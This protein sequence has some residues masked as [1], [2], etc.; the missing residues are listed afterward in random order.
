MCALRICVLT[1]LYIY[2]LQSINKEIKNKYFFL[3][4]EIHNMNFKIEFISNSQR[5]VWVSKLD[6]R[7]GDRI[8]NFGSSKF[9][10]FYRIS[11]GGSLS[12]KTGV[13]NLEIQYIKKKLQIPSYMP[14]IWYHKAHVRSRFSTYT[15]SAVK[16]RQKAKVHDERDRNI[17]NYICMKDMQWCV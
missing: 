5:E 6:K 17:D 10:Q 8:N 1:S 4:Q 14:T 11:H 2:N 16:I 13:E 12:H 9:H 7:E 3:K 15:Y